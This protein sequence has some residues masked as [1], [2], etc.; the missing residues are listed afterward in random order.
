MKSTKLVP[1]LAITSIAM[2]STTVVTAQPP[3]KSQGM[4]N[5]L[6][7][8]GDDLVSIEEFEVPSRGREHNRL[9][10]ADRDGDGNVSRSEKWRLSVVSIGTMMAISTPMSYPLCEGLR[11]TGVQAD[12][13]VA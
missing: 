4:I 7:K 11:S 6:D 3:H 1:I 8:D 2:L 9:V 12:K 5:H 10:T 13:L